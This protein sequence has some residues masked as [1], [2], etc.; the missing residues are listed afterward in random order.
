[1]VARILIAG[2]IITVAILPQLRGQPL[3][4]VSFSPYATGTNGQL[5]LLII[6]PNVLELAIT[7]SNSPSRSKFVADPSRLP[8]PREL[9]VSAEGNPIQV[10]KVG[11]RQRVSYAPL[12]Q[13]DLR[14]GK[15]LFLQLSTAI[16]TNTEVK[17]S[18]GS[19]N[20]VAGFQPHR[21]SPAIHANQVGYEAKSPKIAFIGYYLGT[22]GELDTQASVFEVIAVATGQ[23]VFSGKLRP[24]SDS[25]F[26]YSAYDRVYE[27]DF[28]AFQTPGEYVVHVPGLGISCPFFI[29]PGISAAFARTY[30][31]GL[32][33]QR[34]GSANAMPFTR[35][36]HLP[37]HT[38][39]AEV[40]NMTDRHEATNAELERET[41]GFNE[42]PRHKAPRLKDVKSSLYPF[43]NAK[44]VNVSGGHHDAGDYSKYTINSAGFIHHLTFAVDNFPGV[45]GLDNLGLPESADGIGDVLQ[46]AK[47]EADFLARMQDADGGFY[48]LVYPRGRA[49]ESDVPPDKGDPQVVW[50]KT[51]SATAAAVAALAQCSSS[52]AFRKAFPEAASNYLAKARLGW[53]FL[54]RAFQRFGEDAAYQK[55]THYG[56]EFIH[57]DEVAWA[58]VEM[59]LATGEAKFS[60]QVGKRLNPSDPAFRKW[61]WWRLYDAYGCAI[62]SYAFSV[63]SGRLKKDQVDELLVEKCRLEVATAG[64]DQMKRSESSA[65]GVSFPIETKRAR[66]AGWFFPGDAAFDLTTACQ[67]D[68]PSARDPRPRMLHAIYANLNYEAGANPVNRMYVTGIGW[69]GQREIVHQHAQNDRRVSPPTGIPLGA[70]Q[71]GMLWIDPYKDE[72]AK[73]SWPRDDSEGA[74]YPFYD[75]WGDT[76]NLSQEFVILNQARSLAYTAWLMAQTPL[77]AQPWKPKPASIS[78]SAAQVPGSYQA[79]LNTDQID[80]G[81][82]RILWECE[83]QEPVITP[84]TTLSPSRLRP[85]W[86]EAEA[87]LPDGRRIFA[88]T[89][90][91]TR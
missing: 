16:P 13:Y 58:A 37:C 20:A 33:H 82:S 88:V 6:T 10:S 19:W 29:D 84:H 54:E 32:Y 50:P 79:K 27:A 15:S 23:N 55:I 89:N 66:S 31:I 34:C 44:S 3:K 67:L 45:S 38:N 5:Q 64:E 70:I 76:F 83:G 7:E 24:R 60:A 57:D 49:Y 90:S 52:P 41:E 78:F 35:Y 46:E 56:D 73:L 65:Y 2:F 87:W 43:V 9:Q 4:P 30:A 11:Y 72:P 17:V 48:F 28:T 22:L 36:T 8:T 14:I 18:M 39:A 40:P 75:R 51:T 69:R 91:P 77:R 61:G 81:K 12:K 71:G 53:T 86:I 63:Q 80:L 26:P 74:P 85:K 25:G 21:W 42:D 68:Y 47:W 62:R 1:M 59:F